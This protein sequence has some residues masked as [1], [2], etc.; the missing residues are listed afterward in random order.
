MGKLARLYEAISGSAKISSRTDQTEYMSYGDATLPDFI[1]RAFKKSFI[2]FAKFIWGKSQYYYLAFAKIHYYIEKVVMSF[3]KQI[4]IVA[5][6]RGYGKT[7]FISVLFAIYGIFILKRK[8]IIL[9]SYSQEKSL[10]NLTDIIALIE[11]DRFKKFFKWKR[12]KVWRPAKPSGRVEID[13]LDKFGVIRHTAILRGCGIFQGITG[14]SSKEYRPDLEIWDDIED[15]LKAV[16]KEQ[17]DKL[18]IWINKIAIPGL[19]NMDRDGRQGQIIWIGTPHGSGC[20]LDRAMAKKWQRDVTI[21]KIPAIVD[22]KFMSAELINFL[23]IPEGQSIW[24]EMIPTA[25]ILRKREDFIQRGALSEF[26]LEYMMDSTVDKKLRFDTEKNK[27]IAKYE[28]VKVLPEA[29]RLIC[30]IDM[31][32]TQQTYS[33]YVGICLAAH[34]PRSRMVILKGQKFKFSTDE[35]Y[36]YIHKIYMDYE[37]FAD[38]LAFYAE[39]LQ[40]QLIQSYLDERN[41]RSDIALEIFPIAE[42]TKLNKVNR[43]I[44]MISYHNLGLLE[45]VEDDCIPLLGEMAQWDGTKGVSK[46]PGVDDALDA[47]AYQHD[48]SEGSQLKDLYNS[49]SA[50]TI[51][52]RILTN[53]DYRDAY[54]KSVEQKK[55]HRISSFFDGY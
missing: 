7:K 31:A 46:R 49:E 51:E 9:L 32:Y 33:D 22:P 50:E 26:Q 19:S 15:P 43:I 30:V 53:K 14:A 23:G 4:T 3:R 44:R 42:N 41:L 5:I 54:Y 36:D 27:L 47:F 48:F 37:P 39:S 52:S 6:P 11:T 18:Q 38:K 40:I 29:L 16:I 45:F 35:L 20:M 55:T 8:Y 13:I 17:V 12:G 34:F 28:L 1:A 25:A 21:V 10:E 24:E 2:Y